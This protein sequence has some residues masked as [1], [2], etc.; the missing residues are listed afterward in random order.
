[1]N[2]HIFQEK[3][4][5]HM[6]RQVKGLIVNQL[7]SPFF[8]NKNANNHFYIKRVKEVTYVTLGI[9]YATI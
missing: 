8:D 4:V 9:K 1:M 7:N 5:K 3:K 6:P 2:E